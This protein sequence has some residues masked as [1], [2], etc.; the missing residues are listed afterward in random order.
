[1]Y[2]RPGRPLL[3]KVL[4]NP[5][6]GLPVPSVLVDELGLD[7][8]TRWADLD[9]T[10]WRDHNWM[11]VERLA[12]ELTSFI[13][14]MALE[15]I[16]DTTLFEDRPAVGSLTLTP[17]VENA[18]RRAGMVED[19]SLVPAR[20]RELM[21]ISNFGIKALLEVLTGVEALASMPDRPVGET[22]VPQARISP[23]VR[24]AAQALGRK[25]W[26]RQVSPDDPRV[27]PI[28][29]PIFREASTIAEIA[30][31][32][33]EQDYTPGE[34]RSMVARIR[35]SVRELDALRQLTLAEELLDVLRAVSGRRTDP[36][37]VARLGL[38]GGEPTTLEQASERAGVTRERV[39]QLEKAFRQRVQDVDRLWLPVLDRAVGLADALV[40]VASHALEEAL[41]AEGLADDKFSVESLVTACDV[42]GRA[43]PFEIAPD[44]LLVR[45]GR[46]E[47]TTAIRSTASR[48]VEHW[49]ATTIADVQA[50]L[51]DGGLDPDGATTRLALE[52]MDGF[53]WL[54]GD[55]RWFWIAGTRN[56]VLNQV[57]KIMSVAGSI[58]LND[59]RRGVGRHH[60]MS[61][62]RPPRE[63][64]AALCVQSGLYSR[65][66]DVIIGGPDLPDWR[67]LLGRN[68]R[69]LAAT[70]FDHGPVMRRD[71]LVRIVVDERGLKVNSVNIYLGYSP[72]IERFAP[73]VY[74]LRGARVGAAEVEVLIPPR[75][76]HQVLQDHG[77][78]GD[79]RL[80]M[81][82]R[83][84]PS[85]AS[86]GV[87]GTPA[88]VRDVAEGSFPLFNEDG[89]PVGTL[90]V[91]NNMWGLSP[92]F[93]R[94][95]VE[96]GDYVVLSLDTRKRDA[97]ISAG[98]EE[99][100]L[101]FQSGE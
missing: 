34:A 32:L 52:T 68:E 96:A 70:L 67:E 25:R 19:G 21:T 6:G 76:R 80:W 44:G 30:A 18:L 26:S 43:L 74:G 35:R 54:D 60:R 92:F 51:E 33:A 79:G 85:S 100:L 24:K 37:L 10:V 5:L 28:L 93:H 56:R 88:A 63:V 46:T 20:I 1:M 57:E 8:D 27:A 42:F 84:S 22:H 29:G 61:G 40:P 78:T 58:E 91:A 75:V 55:K 87:L 99:L 98:T 82:F 94:W 62:F 12:H 41:V 50:R 39:R 16:G 3:P 11:A 101:R 90:V 14:D 49:G 86:T 9:E 17:R 53:S 2:P 36:A 45:P 7:C 89:E 4:R 81:A 31:W 66:G 64:L 73:G 47:L 95:G 59:L 83:L 77:W 69:V 38:D 15:R 23:A 65:R 48:L 13:D 71:D 97:S 72:I